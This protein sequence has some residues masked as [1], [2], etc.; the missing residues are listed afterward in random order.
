M[1]KKQWINVGNIVLY[2]MRDFEDKVDIIHV[3]KDAVLE[4]LLP[5]MD[6]TFLKKD[7]TE[8]YDYSVD[9][10]KDIPVKHSQN[11]DINYNIFDYTDDEE[12]DDI[13]ID[14]I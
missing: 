10:S 1:R 8:I 6:L 13:N 3:Y 7:D 2:S 9:D 4:R 5:K 14:D 11:N 12:D